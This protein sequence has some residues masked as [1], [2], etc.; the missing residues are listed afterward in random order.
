MIKSIVFERIKTTLPANN[1]SIAHNLR[2]RNKN[3]NAAGSFSLFGLAIK[4]SA[5]LIA[6]K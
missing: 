5:L 4:I 2:Q 1:F 6:V 3:T